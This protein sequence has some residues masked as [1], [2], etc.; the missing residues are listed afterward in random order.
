MKREKIGVKS[1]CLIMAICLV[2]VVLTESGS[3]GTMS[4]VI[5]NGPNYAVVGYV[6]TTV[7]RNK[8][9][10]CSMGT[11]HERG[12]PAEVIEMQF[13]LSINTGIT[14]SWAPTF[15]APL[16]ELET[17]LGIAQSIHQTIVQTV[18]KTISSSKP[19]GWYRIEH[20]EPWCGVTGKVRKEGMQGDIVIYE[21]SHE[22]PIWPG[23]IL[24]RYA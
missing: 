22:G 9:N 14:G 12:E 15:K 24:V 10:G 7:L 5:G 11:H 4:K 3:A 17:S 21:D 1:L 2:L 16:L 19:T 20:R 8:I 13:H 18:R 23:F 6:T